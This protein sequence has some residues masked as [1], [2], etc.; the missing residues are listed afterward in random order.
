[1]LKICSLKTKNPLPADALVSG[2]SNPV[3]ELRYSYSDRTP[4]PAVA[5]QQHGQHIAAQELRFINSILPRPSLITNYKKQRRVQTATRR[6][7]CS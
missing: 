6:H 4:A 1:M 3:I 7:F 5:L 2:Y